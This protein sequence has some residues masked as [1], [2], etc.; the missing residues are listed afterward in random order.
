M[1]TGLPR[2]FLRSVFVDLTP[3]RSSIRFRWLF[4]GLVGGGLTRQALVV[5]VPY[6]IFART[7]STLLVGLAGLVQV[8]PLAVFALVGGVVAD[9]MDRAKVLM[10]VEGGVAIT[11]ALMALNSTTGQVW[12]LFVLVVLNAAC[13]G[14]ENPTRTALV[15]SLVEPACSQALSRST[16]RYRRP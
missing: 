2:R 5:A 12:P 4:A 6:E 9:A 1:T 14:V 13:F 15:P 3:L 7:N 8:I 16:N 10:A 11:A